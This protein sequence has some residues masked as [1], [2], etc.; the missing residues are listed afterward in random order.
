MRRIPLLLPLLLASSA[1]LAQNEGVMI[2]KSEQPYV[3]PFDKAP[4]GRPA[5]AAT[6]FPPAAEPEAAPHG[7]AVNVEV[8]EM[9]KQETQKRA[10]AFVSKT[11]PKPAPVRKAD[12]RKAEEPRAVVKREEPKA[13]PVVKREEP[14][15]APV[16]K[17]ELK[18]APVKTEPK[19]EASIIP[20]KEAQNPKAE[21]APPPALAVKENGLTSF[22][23]ETPAASAPV[24]VE[25]AKP[26]VSSASSIPAAATTASEPTTPALTLNENTDVAQN[27]GVFPGWLLKAIMFFIIGGLLMLGGWY[28]IKR[29]ALYGDPAFQ[30]PWFR[31]VKSR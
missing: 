19:V 26:S 30:D 23:K 24:T 14:K 21:L 6:L 3:S 11:Q 22:G 20:P 9:E 28:W 8:R 18:A 31:P 29:Q 5:P 2:F 4:S 13:A 1:V 12:A 25:P 7:E 17:T 16:A 27:E 15:Q 10:Q